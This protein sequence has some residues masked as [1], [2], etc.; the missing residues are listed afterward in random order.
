MSA[1]L[2]QGNAREHCYDLMSVL[3]E[4]GRIDFQVPETQADPRLSLDYLFGEARGQMFGIL[5]CM[6]PDGSLV[7][8]RAFSGQYNG[9]WEVDGWVSPILDVDRFA[10]LVQGTDSRIKALGKQ[11]DLLP[12]GEARRLLAARR[13]KLS[14]DLMTRYSRTVSGSQFLF[15][16]ETAFRFFFKRNSHRRR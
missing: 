5:E 9:V 1:I 15:R 7:I 3:E 14:Q 4:K 2:Q 8:L 12:E 16:G 11:I 6:D 13:K 10:E